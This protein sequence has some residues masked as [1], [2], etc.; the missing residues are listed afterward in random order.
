MTFREGNND[1]ISKSAENAVGVVDY[2][3]IDVTHLERCAEFWA[4]VLG[5]E[6]IG[7][8]EDGY[9]SL[10]R[11]QEGAPLVFIQ[12]VP[13][14]KTVK[15][16]VHLDIRVADVDA[17]IAK[18]KSLGGSLLR[19]VASEEYEP[20]QNKFATHR[21]AIMTDPDGNEFCLH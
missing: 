3:G 9:I 14:R 19:V 10:Q 21:F 18:V 1:D 5:V 6:I 2:I 8:W 13:E 11:Q 4:L 16:R 12:K 17:A 15:N 7:E 20:G